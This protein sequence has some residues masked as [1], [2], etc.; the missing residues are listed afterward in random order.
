M[1]AA[2]LW[3]VLWVGFVDALAGGALLGF[4]YT[5]ESN[6]LMLGVSG[7]LVILAGALLLLSSASA[8]H[9]L[10]HGGRP[11]TSVGAAARRLPLVL[12]AVL[13]LGVICG[14][15]G[16]FESWWIAR[17]GEVD[18]A[19]IV[20]GDITRTGW[21]H[22]AVHWMVVTI[23]WILVPAWLAT[24]L[25]WVAGYERRDVL[26]L[27]WLTA[28]L[29]W[30][31]IAVTA[32][33]VALLVWLPMRYVYWRPRSLPASSAEVVFA[34]AKL[35]IIYLLT[36]LA[37]ALVLWVAA[38]RVLPAAVSPLATPVVASDLPR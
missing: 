37:W 26:T 12:V 28:G 34:G 19:A 6:V 15:A 35:L 20:A 14:G 25:A 11:W 8:S 16:W 33:G 31:L 22:T 18:A 24:A 36:Q 29:H 4:L 10:V 21:L 32:I 9:A 7:L 30:Q 17:A 2:I 5:P 23:Q 1:S 3:T 13:V 38:R 27:K